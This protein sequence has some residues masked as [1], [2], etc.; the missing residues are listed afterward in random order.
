MYIESYILLH[1]LTNKQEPCTESPATELDGNEMPASFMIPRN[2]D[3]SPLLVFRTASKAA[4]LRDSSTLQT[5]VSLSSTETYRSKA[6]RVYIG[7]L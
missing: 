1:Q 4:L 3:L 6:Q 5:I 7:Q 2:A